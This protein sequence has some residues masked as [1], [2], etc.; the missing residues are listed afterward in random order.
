[1]VSPPSPPRATALPHAE[2]P[3]P[4]CCQSLPFLKPSDAPLPHVPAYLSC[5][6]SHAF[7][8]TVSHFSHHMLFPL[9]GTFFPSTLPS[10]LLPFLLL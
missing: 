4:T 3:L 9:K 1:M 6:F 10:Q 2:T 8:V 7:R 5:L